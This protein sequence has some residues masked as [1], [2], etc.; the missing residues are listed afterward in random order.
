MRF[1]RKDQRNTHQDQ[2]IP[3]ICIHFMRELCKS[4]GR[5]QD[6]LHNTVF[7]SPISLHNASLQKQ[8]EGPA[9]NPA[10]PIAGI[11]AFLICRL[12]S[13]HNITG[14]DTRIESPEILFSFLHQEGVVAVPVLLS[15]NCKIFPFRVCAFLCI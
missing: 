6:L 11:M 7:K 5:D 12:P 4:L 15:A 14:L 13:F 8:P 10:M 3:L 1:I 9:R 2:H